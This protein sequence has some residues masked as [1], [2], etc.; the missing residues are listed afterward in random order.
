VLQRFPFDADRVS[1]LGADYH[2]WRKVLGDDHP[3]LAL[4][5]N[6]LAYNLHY[7]GR[8][9]DA[10]PLFEKALALARRG[11]GE[12]H[13]YTANGYNS[14][15]RW[16]NTPNRKCACCPRQGGGMCAGPSRG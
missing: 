12:D 4:G 10:Q 3:D 7:Q 2:T 15:G 5:Y 6:N 13:P 11:L 14:L 8:Y 1:L 9:A 16:P